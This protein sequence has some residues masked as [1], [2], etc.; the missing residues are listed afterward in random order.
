LTD[1]LRNKVSESAIISIDLTSF[2]PVADPVCFDL[3]IYLYKGLILRE[4]DFRKDLSEINTEQFKDQTVLVYCSADAIIP[5]WAYML[6]ASVLTPVAS[7]VFFG[8]IEK[9]TS[10]VISK[11]IKEMDTG[12][13]LDARVVVKGCGEKRIPEEAYF[14][15]TKKLLPIARSIMYGEPCSTVPIFKRK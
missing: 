9:W 13:Y 6:T 5:V 1:V 2:L 8:G 7:N 11:K 10:E 3:S 12:P 15:I 14:E 4:K